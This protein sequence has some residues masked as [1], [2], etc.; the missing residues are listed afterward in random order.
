MACV[1]EIKIGAELRS[2]SS[3]IHRFENRSYT[4]QIYRN[5]EK[6][7]CLPILLAA[8]PSDPKDTCDLDVA[9]I[10]MWEG[11]GPEG[12]G[13]GSQ[14]RGVIPIQ[15]RGRICGLLVS[16]IMFPVRFGCS[17]VTTHSG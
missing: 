5:I 8:K 3:G 11:S 2:V 4:A 12:A 10:I 6:T 17:L 7:T 14:C 15:G 16:S 13:W 9:V 1:R